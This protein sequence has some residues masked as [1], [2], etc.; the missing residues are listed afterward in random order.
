M[1]A[2]AGS[3]EPQP[4]RVVA[5]AKSAPSTSILNSTLMKHSNLLLFRGAI[6]TFGGFGVGQLFRFG[7]NVILTH[8]L[9]PDLF[10]IMII[11]NSVRTGV[12]L[13]S[14]FGI[15]QNIVHNKDA[16]N[17]DFYN[18]A[19]TL[20]LIRAL[21]LWLIISAAANPV[22]HFYNLPILA[23]ALPVAGFFFIIVGLGSL[24]APLLQKRLRFVRLNIYET[25]LEIASAISHIAIAYLSPTIWGLIF[26]G[27][28]AMASR[29]I[30]SYFILPS[31]RH[32]L[33][34]STKYAWQIVS[35]GKW[36]FLSS[37]VYFLAMNFDR[38][39]YAKVSALGL[40]GV[41]G[42]ARALSDLVVNFAS[43]LSTY[44]VFPLVAELQDHPRMELRRTL[45]GK[46]FAV[47]LVGAVGIAVLITAADIA[48][49]TI[50][51][52]RYYGAAWMLPILLA[53]TWFSIVSN[54][55][56]SMLLG[57]G[58][59]V[60]SALANGSKLAWLVVSV[61]VSFSV[62]GTFGAV[63]AVAISDIWRYFPILVGQTREGVSFAKQDLFATFVM[64]I[65]L[66]ICELSRWK[67][68]F[69]TSFDHLP[70]G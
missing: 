29:S 24:A 47:I 17:P 15:A 57:I 8:L 64:I 6:W 35:F 11:V 61:P 28:F 65:V 10:G 20:R 40:V 5:S 46:R 45:M 21:I 58:K 63:V 7:T 13:L 68:G 67:F 22:A 60:Y 54:I 53:G 42:I 31:I 1:D 26:G 18:T 55:N 44:L 69:G 27:L 38:L 41:Y 52:S 34:L 12:D 14:D 16:E 25:A 49:K 2:D 62:F 36:I 50:Y 30:G 3:Q 66:S 33:R 59:P 39:Y 56:E 43:R 4:I 32:R 48:I 70:I 51:D 19:W 37:F 23:T 9:A